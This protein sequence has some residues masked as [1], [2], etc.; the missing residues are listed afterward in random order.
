MFQT[1]VLHE[2]T[3]AANVLAVS[4]RAAQHLHE[5]SRVVAD[6]AFLLR[7]NPEHPEHDSLGLR[8]AKDM[9]APELLV[10]GGSRVYGSGV[11][12][13]ECWP[14]Q[15]G[16]RMGGGVMNAGIPGWGSVQYVLAA[17]EL[18][19]LSPRRV[20]VALTPASDL[21]Q[22]LHCARVSASPLAR[23]F[24]EGRWRSLPP[25]D[26]SAILRTSRAISEY[27]AAH[28]DLGGEEVLAALARRR[29]QDVD[30]CIIEESGFYLSA[31]SLFAMQDLEQPA[32]A[33]GLAITVKVLEHLHELAREQRFP[34]AVMLFPSREY[35]VFQRME[36]ARLR[37]RLALERLGLA[38]AAVL[39]ELR[40]ACAGMGLRCIDLSPF[41]RQ[42]VGQGI[43]IQSSRQGQYTPQ[44]CERIARFVRERIL[45]GMI[46]QEPLREA[47]GDGLT[48]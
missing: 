38:E 23:S 2:A 14:A 28:P 24:M 13:S 17:E 4:E 6:P 45:P 5:P 19:E 29:V 10:I 11:S 27:A 8:N 26:D 42:C 15:L 37:D 30:P 40:A 35:L 16:A 31:H 21:T 9:N 22:A 43:Y 12:A 44:G 47:A 3:A 18:A 46:P 41:L 32:I 7:G 20:I 36:D 39:G 25:A 34:L 48:Y 33:A 1:S